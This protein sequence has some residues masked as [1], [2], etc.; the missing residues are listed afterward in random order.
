MDR[1]AV[2]P[3]PAR[4][5]LNAITPFLELTMSLRSALKPVT[6]ATLL[7]LALPT[8]SSAPRVTVRSLG[9]GVA[10][11]L[12]DAGQVVGQIN[13][14]PAVWDAQGQRTVLSDAEGEA[15]GISSDGQV[16]GFFRPDGT[17]RAFRASPGQGLETLPMMSGFPMASAYGINARGEVVGG[18][19]IQGS[20]GAYWGSNGQAQRLS[21]RGAPSAVLGQ[22][23]NDAGWIAGRAWRTSGE[24]RTD[25]GM[26]VQAPGQGETLI[27]QGRLNALG[28][29]GQ[30]AGQ[31][32]SGRA[33]VWTP[34]NGMQS[35]GTLGGATSVAYGVNGALQVVGSS[36]AAVGATRSF[37]WTAGGGMRDLSGLLPGTPFTAV[38]I[39][40]HAQILANTAAGP[41]I[42]SLQP[43]WQGGSGN[44][45]GA[46]WNWSGTGT[47]A[48][49][50]GAMHDAVINPGETVTVRGALEGRARSLQVGGTAGSL[51]SFDLNGGSTRLGDG[52]DPI[53]RYSEIA[54]GGVLRGSGLL[55][56]Q[57][58]LIVRAGGRVQVD[59][60]QAMQLSAYSASIDAGG[61]IRAQG[62]S[63]NLARLELIGSFSNAGQ[64]QFQHADVVATG[65]LMNVGR[66]SLQ[67][68]QLTLDG[69][70]YNTWGG[71]VA[72]S[73]GEVVLNGD[74]HNLGGLFLVSNG[75]RATLNGSFDNAS[76]DAELRVSAGGAL[77]VLGR[78]SGGGYIT[79]DGELRLEGGLD[80]APEGGLVTQVAPSTLLRGDVHLGAATTLQF[81]RDVTLDGAALRVDGTAGPLS[82]GA[83]LDLFDWG[84]GVQGSFSAIALPTLVDGVTWD[85]SQLYTTGD[86]FAVTAQV[87]E[88]ASLLLWALGL[89]V[90][91][92]GRSGRPWRV[93][94][95][96]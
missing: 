10:L 85:L 73:F 72:V 61:L 27:G 13:N 56:V 54:Q 31:D 60:G 5:R 19:Y 1:G 83:V 37:L 21:D 84:G 42:L 63:Q 18:F 11:A 50:L 38:G 55:E 20:I 88:P 74:V 35:L 24:S 39:N 75:G 40:G 49:T 58:D 44:W 79:G 2:I 15:R 16:T 52:G 57:E 22:F 90:L 96:A 66:L 34:G 91:T 94:S 8:A 76:S 93:A 80:V 25:D 4:L 70:L 64:M 65:P 92:A 6:L 29:D 86:V 41:V 23:I 69:A 45:D 17:L 9:S 14:R 68:S 28:P 33:F 43:D 46:H 53:V 30:A 7:C 71:Q 81:G 82:A 26:F 51:V 12:N 47:A 87:P 95:R 77:T 48:A 78:Y 62:T 32:S 89:I 67:S 59:A 36:T 3:R